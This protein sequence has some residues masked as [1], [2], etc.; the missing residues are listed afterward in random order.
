MQEVLGYVYASYS[1]LPCRF[2]DIQNIMYISRYT[3][4]DGFEISVPS[5]NAVDLTKA[6]IE[7]RGE[8]KVNWA[9]CQR[10]SKA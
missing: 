6:I 3:G 4:E 7:R 2:L 5:E 8:D 9:W 1:Y 10:Q